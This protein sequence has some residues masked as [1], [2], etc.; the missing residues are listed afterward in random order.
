MQRIVIALAAAA[1]VNIVT[2]ANASSTLTVAAIVA[3][4]MLMGRTAITA[5]SLT[6]TVSFL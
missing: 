5:C 6:A 1:I 4:S 3:V 2:V